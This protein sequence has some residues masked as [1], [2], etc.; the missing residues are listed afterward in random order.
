MPKKKNNP[1]L[2]FFIFLFLRGPSC[3]IKFYYLH[4]TVCEI[5]TLDNI[6]DNNNKTQLLDLRHCNHFYSS[7]CLQAPGTRTQ[8]HYASN[9]D[10]TH[11]QT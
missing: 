3:S 2:F 1:N 6:C 9:I 5:P 11:K 8:A 4:N 10:A 7:Q